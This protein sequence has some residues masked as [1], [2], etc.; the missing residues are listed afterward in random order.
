MIALEDIRN[1]AVVRGI[2]PNQSVQVVSVDWIGNQAINVV[3]RDQNGSVSETTSTA[4][5]S[6][7]LP[8]TPRDG[9]GRS[10]PTAACSGS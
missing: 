10:M 1:G 2:A 3:F 6:I 8:S 5:M 7:A 4:M 9:P